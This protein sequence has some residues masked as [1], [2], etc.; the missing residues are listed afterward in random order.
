[1]I[2]TIY[3]IRLNGS[4]IAEAPTAEAAEQA[5]RTLAPEFAVNRASFVIVEPGAEYREPERSAHVATAERVERQGKAHR[6][7]A[8]CS[9][10]WATSCDT[11]SKAEA[12]GWADAHARLNTPT[13]EV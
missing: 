6:Y 13:T 5:T 4:L 2:A 10:G 1:M 3:E 9:C 12:Q 7:T 8:R 11:S